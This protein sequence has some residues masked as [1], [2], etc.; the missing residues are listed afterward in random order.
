MVGDCCGDTI[1]GCCEDTIGGSA[2]K[3]RDVPE[4]RERQSAVW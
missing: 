4:E 2:A 1:G 3:E